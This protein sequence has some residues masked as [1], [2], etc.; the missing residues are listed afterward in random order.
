MPHFGPRPGL[1]LGEASSFWPKNSQKAQLGQIEDQN[2]DLASNFAT[3]SRLNI[4]PIFARE[5]S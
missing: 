2:L 3:F 1:T 4:Y 5:K